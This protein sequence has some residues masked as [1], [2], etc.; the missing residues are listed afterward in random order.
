MRRPPPAERTLLLRNHPRPGW[1][2]DQTFASLL[3]GQPEDPTL[4]RKGTLAIHSLI[5]PDQH[6]HL[7]RRG[8]G[9]AAKPGL[10]PHASR[11]LAG[12]PDSGSYRQVG[13][14]L[15]P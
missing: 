7:P 2:E 15:T 1:Q 4:E 13:Q 10:L 6:P 12:R 14:P 9:L 5:L 11:T 8:H 3:K